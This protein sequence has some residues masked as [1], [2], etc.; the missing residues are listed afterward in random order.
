MWNFCLSYSLKVVRIMSKVDV[1][2]LEKWMCGLTKTMK[3]MVEAMPNSVARDKAMDGVRVME[4]AVFSY[5]YS[6]L[7]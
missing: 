4:D 6:Y 1:F 3:A 5:G 2:D 7:E